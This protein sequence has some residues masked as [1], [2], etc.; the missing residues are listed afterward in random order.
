LVF[1]HNPVSESQM[2][3]LD[4]ELP[5]GEEFREQQR[6]NPRPANPGGQPGMFAQPERP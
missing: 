6:E 5:S 4:W 2:Q 1:S 3:A